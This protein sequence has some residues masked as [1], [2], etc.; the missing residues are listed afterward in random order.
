MTFISVDGRLHCEILVLLPTFNCM[1][2]IDIRGH[3]VELSTGRHNG[4]DFNGTNQSPFVLHDVVAKFVP[5]T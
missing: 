3:D 5:I 1:R 4:E 2:G